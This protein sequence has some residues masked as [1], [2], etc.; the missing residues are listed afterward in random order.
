[1]SPIQK[2][3]LKLLLKDLAF[4]GA[5][6]QPST[7][8]LTEMLYYVCIAGDVR[9]VYFASKNHHPTTVHNENEC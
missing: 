5:R 1:M 4:I 9:I 6:L 7:E 2:L 3:F 8:A